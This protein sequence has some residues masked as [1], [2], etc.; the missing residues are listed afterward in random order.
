MHPPP[1]KKKKIEKK[2]CVP[3]PPPQKKIYVCPQSVIASYGPV[4]WNEFKDPHTL[5]DPTEPKKLGL[6]LPPLKF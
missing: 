4:I 6:L 3:P 5:P 1:P 2:L